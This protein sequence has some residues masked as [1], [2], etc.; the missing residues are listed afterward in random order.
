MK[1]QTLFSKITAILL[2]AI[3]ALSL[4]SCARGGG[5]ADNYY[6][7]MGDYESSGKDSV[8]GS[9]AAN[10]SGLGDI[11]VSGAD[12]P[13]A[14]II[15]TA[16]ASVRTTDYETVMNAVFEKITAL[17]GYTD[18]ESFSGS[19]PYRY[20]YITIR[21]PAESLDEFKNELS[22]IATLTHY[23]AKKDDVTVAYAM[24]VAR[25]DTLKL[26][27]DVVKDLFEIA[28][29]EG[30]ISSIAELEGRLSDLQLDLAESEAKLQAYDNSIAYSTLYL[31][32]NETKKTE[33]VAQE[34]PPTVFERI[35]A[36]LKTNFK[37]IGNFFVE[38]FVFIV[39]ALPYLVIIA[40]IVT[41]VILITVKKIKNRKVKKSEDTPSEEEK[42]N[43]ENA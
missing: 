19:S 32:V 11:T 30:S 21:I 16:E 2:L 14:K 13:N 43:G 31:T 10:G 38:F 25:I 7:S 39:S 40:V 33:P 35:G 18:K 28:K 42:T 37:D 29:A 6:P 23:S 12:N 4:V 34:D 3:F 15:K 5:A 27:I 41:A 8:V 22:E 24:L 9:G 36:N 17:E 1:K 20:A 26:E